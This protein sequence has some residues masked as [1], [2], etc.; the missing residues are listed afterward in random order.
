MNAVKKDLEWNLVDP[1]DGTIRD[2]N[3]SK[4]T[5]GTNFRS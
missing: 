4:K 5:L 2:T 1:N 3:E